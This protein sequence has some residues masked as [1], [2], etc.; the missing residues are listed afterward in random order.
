MNKTN[1]RNCIY[2]YIYIYILASMA[3]INTGKNRGF[4][5]KSECK[6]GRLLADFFGSSCMP[7]ARDILHDRNQDNPDSLCTLCKTMITV[8]PPPTI[9]MPA[10]LVPLGW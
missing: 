2:I 7:G 6:Y 8:G 1:L 5:D 4:F 3:F 10:P 9:I